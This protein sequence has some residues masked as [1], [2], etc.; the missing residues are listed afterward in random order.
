MESRI[1]VVDDAEDHQQVVRKV[2]DRLCR[3][4][5][6]FTLAEAE[7]ELAKNPFDLILLD[8]TLPDGDG[9]SFFA[10]LR[11]QEHT[12]GIPVIFVTSKTDTP[13]EAMGFSLG[14]EDYVVKPVDPARLRARI[15]AR[16]RM[17]QSRQERELQ[18]CKGDIKLSVSLQRAAIIQEG[19]EVPISL[20]P[21]EFKLLFHL[22]RYDDKIFTREQLL[23]AIWDD[24][25]E[26]FERTVDMHV[27]KLRK[28]I[29]P[30]FYEIKAVHGMGYRLSK[31]I[32]SPANPP[33]GPP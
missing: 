19:R 23:T 21:V 5:P 31:K 29:A 22:L 7:R 13:N 20:T 30:S 4:V 8:V 33:A 24:A 16:L 18:L 28:K 25:S 10:K 27:S 2:L 15:E 12:S 14:A 6:A 32:V 17:I 11:T 1:L 3:V 9:F 26:V